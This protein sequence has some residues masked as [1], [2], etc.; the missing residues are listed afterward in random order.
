MRIL[1]V[2]KK[3]A[4]QALRSKQFRKSLLRYWKFCNFIQIVDRL[5]TGGFQKYEHKLIFSLEM[6]NYFPNISN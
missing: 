1:S 6:W 5:K 4:G 2:P 3:N